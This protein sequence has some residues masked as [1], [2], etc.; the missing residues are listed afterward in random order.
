[1]H[2]PTYRIAHITLFVISDVEHWLEG[3]KNSSMGP[4][5]GIDPTTHRTVSYIS[6]LKRTIRTRTRINNANEVIKKPK[7]NQHW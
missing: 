2:H 4:P 3:E 7:Q 5:R 1:M 6:L